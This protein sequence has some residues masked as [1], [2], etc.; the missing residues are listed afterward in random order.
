[1]YFDTEHTA[2]WA[3][4]YTSLMRARNRIF[5][6]KRSRDIGFSVP[7]TLIT[8]DL[9]HC[10]NFVSQHDSIVK[11]L[12]ITSFQALGVGANV[13]TKPVKWSNI[14]ALGPESMHC[15][16][17]L[18]ERIKVQKE[19]RIVYAFGEV[20]A[21]HIRRKEGN[22]HLDIRKGGPSE[23]EN[24]FT[25][26][27]GACLDKV[28]N[29][30]RSLDLEF[31]SMDILTDGLDWYLIDLNPNGQWLWLEL[32]TRADISGAFVRKYIDLKK[33]QDANM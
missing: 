23:V 19:Y 15:P 32:D 9:T 4:K 24:Y 2:V 33:Q 12:D 17:V 7:E 10:E 11:P 5:Q 20:F 8:N 25:E 28:L 27:D 30:M 18:Q 29:V 3:N 1:M 6:L 21:F 16:Q 13:F 22:N 14:D 26:L 31:A